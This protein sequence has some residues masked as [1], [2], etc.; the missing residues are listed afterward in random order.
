MH[1]PCSYLIAMPTNTTNSSNGWKP[2]DNP[3][4]V[5]HESSFLCCK[6]NIAPSFIG[7]MATFVR[8][9]Q[10]CEL[11]WGVD[12]GRGCPISSGNSKRWR[13]QRSGRDYRISALPG[14]PVLNASSWWLQPC[15]KGRGYHLAQSRAGISISKDKSIR[16]CDELN[17]NDM[18][19]W[20]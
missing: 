3:R 19:W 5:A 7:L 9:C 14:S 15:G 2:L 10:L 8:L 18:N 11:N 6:G 16:Q 20:L 4:A 17:R 13:L 1:F 12:Y